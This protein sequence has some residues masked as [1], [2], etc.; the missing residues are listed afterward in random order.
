MHQLYWSEGNESEA[1]KMNLI[2]SIGTSQ[3][4]YQKVKKN[5]LFF[6]IEFLSL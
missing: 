6:I 1:V 3:T 2:F 5:K 4:D